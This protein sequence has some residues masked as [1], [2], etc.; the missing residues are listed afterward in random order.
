M[1]HTSASIHDDI[2]TLLSSAKTVAVV[3]CSPDPSRPSARVAGYLRRAGYDVVPVNPTVDEIEG[4]KC[5]ARLGDI[6]GPV[7]IAVVFRRSDQASPHLDEAIA[8][9]VRT[10]WLQQGVMLRDGLARAAAAG[11]AYVEDR[12]I[13]VEHRMRFR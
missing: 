5:Y 11:V 7:D 13:M 6:P 8:K 10:V 12:C 9:R 2:L 4:R 3:G 1:S